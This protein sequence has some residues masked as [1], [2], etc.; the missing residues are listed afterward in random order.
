MNLRRLC[1]AVLFAALPSVLAHAQASPTATRQ[2]DLSAFGGVTGVE[3]GLAGARNLSFAAGA[4]IGFEPIHG[5]RPVV[6]VRGY[7]PM[8]GGHLVS[9]KSI[10][11]GLRAEFML[12]HRLHPY[13]NFLFGRGEMDYGSNFPPFNGYTYIDTTTNI[14]SP[15]GGVDYDLTPHFSVKLDAQFQYW[16]GYSPTPSGNIWNK[17]GTV[18]V[19]Y[20]FGWRNR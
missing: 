20:H 14:Y 4:D 17:M 13:G 10:L 1:L 16:R 2:I 19:V 12:N 3:T 18:G 8:D 15:G 7:Y 5:V 9:Q 6:E 11:G